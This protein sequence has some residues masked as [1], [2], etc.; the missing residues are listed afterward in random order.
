MVAGVGVGERMRGRDSQGV[1]DERV[2]TAI[3][4][5]M[6]NKDLLYS[7]WN[8]A[9]CYVAAWMEEGLGE[10]GY[11][12]MDGWV[13]SLFTQKYHNIDNRIYPNIK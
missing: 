3:F 10:N 1:W 8:S 7:T 5:M 13:P 9:H 11:M 4:K 12:Y 6:T 2:H